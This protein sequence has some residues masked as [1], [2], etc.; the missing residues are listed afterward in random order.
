M[1][2]GYM[3]PI[4]DIFVVNNRLATNMAYEKS[5]IRGLSNKQGA[6]P[7]S[8]WL[9]LFNNHKVTNNLKG[10]SKRYCVNVI[11]CRYNEVQK[12]LY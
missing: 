6:L 8:S 1:E 10:P 12:N 9:Y 5:N 3:R 2:T 7:F 4:R 11:Q